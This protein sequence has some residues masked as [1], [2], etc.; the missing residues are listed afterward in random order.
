MTRASSILSERELRKQFEKETG[1]VAM[2]GT[3]R[4]GKGGRPSAC[5]LGWLEDMVRVWFP[6]L[7]AMMKRDAQKQIAQAEQRNRQTRIFGGTL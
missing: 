4:I 7:S 2:I 1:K 6:E 5:Y 3:D